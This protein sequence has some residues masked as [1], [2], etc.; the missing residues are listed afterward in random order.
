MGRSEDG[1]L[2]QGTLDTLILKA[3]ARRTKHGH[4]LAERIWEVRN[5]LWVWKRCYPALHRLE[6]QRPDRVGVGLPQ[7]IRR[8]KFY[9]SLAAEAACW[10]RMRAAIVRVMGAA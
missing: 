3:L 6:S 7:N 9:R 1:D 4:A 10:S 5:T 8:T 2:L